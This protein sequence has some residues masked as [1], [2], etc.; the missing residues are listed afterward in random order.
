MYIAQI[1]SCV[2]L[3]GP[4][5]SAALKGVAAGEVVRAVLWLLYNPGLFFL[6]RCKR[7]SAVATENSTP[8]A[9]ISATAPGAIYRWH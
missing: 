2:M 3:D 7:L 8:L 5:K 1:C 6:I 4:G 9:S